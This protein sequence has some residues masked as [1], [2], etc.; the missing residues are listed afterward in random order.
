[1]LAAI[2]RDSAVAATAP[3]R[4]GVWD[5]IQNWAAGIGA[6]PDKRLG[7]AFNPIAFLTRQECE[8]YYNGDWVMA[9]AVDKPVEDMTRNW[10]TLVWPG[11]DKDEAATSALADVEDEL[12]IREHVVEAMT[13]G[14]QFGGAALILIISGE[15]DWS[16]P[17]GYKRGAI[18]APGTQPNY[19][20]IGVGDLDLVYPVDRHRLAPTGMADNAR[21]D[22][23]TGKSNQNFGQPLAYSFTDEAGISE[24]NVHWSRVIRFHGKRL[25]R[26]DW[27]RNGRWHASVFQKIQTDVMDYAASRASTATL[28]LEQA[29]DILNIPGLAEKLS[30]PLGRTQVMDRIAF[31]A[32]LKGLNRVWLLDGGN[33]TVNR[34]P[35]MYSQKKVDYSGSAAALE[36]WMYIIS[37]ATGVPVT[38]LFGR[39]PGGLNS[40][41]DSDMKN[42]REQCANG[43]QTDMRPALLRLYEV[44]IRSAIGYMPDDLKIV[45]PPID[46]PSRSE[47]AEI[48]AKE[49]T[50]YKAFVDMGMP[51]GIVMRELK[52]KGTSFTTLEDA[53]VS[54]A[55]D[56]DKQDAE[57]AKAGAKAQA[58]AFKKGEVP[59]APGKTRPAP[60]E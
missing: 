26:Y 11:K 22:P 33:K 42:Y 38:R 44:V 31:G 48:L 41:G 37:G 12:Q 54:A 32:N 16:L 30:T 60:A 3:S 14:R 55:A 5:G 45:F 8:A 47:A 50:A 19:D 24:Y 52:S 17:I 1:M 28:G 57:L 9:A 35:E 20:A 2:G 15:D 46:D 18:V 29:V 25:S 59:G 27:W 53:D 43:Q 58:A 34:D 21:R 56:L 13:W 4:P 23:R 49:A 40:T 10:P 6:G 7:N 39:S 51:L 36:S